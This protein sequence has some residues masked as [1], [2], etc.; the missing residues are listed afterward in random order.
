MQPLLTLLIVS[1]CHVCVG[2][3]Q[4]NEL[5]NGVSSTEDPRDAFIKAISEPLDNIVDEVQ[6][7]KET[8]N[9]NLNPFRDFDREPQSPTLT[10]PRIPN[11][12]NYEDESNLPSVFDPPVQDRR[13]PDR[14]LVDEFGNPLGDIHTTD[15]TR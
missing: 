15:T 10:P 4:L 6:P 3:N 9:Q 7:F 1:I 11:Y 2:Q 5:N 12:P 8:V 14:P 13:G